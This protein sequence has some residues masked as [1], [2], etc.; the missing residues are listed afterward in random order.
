MIKVALLIFALLVPASAVSFPV[1]PLG[2]CFDGV[3]KLCSGNAYPGSEIAYS[4]IMDGGQGHVWL[5]Q[6]DMIIDPY[7]GERSNETVRWV[8]EG[9]FKTFE[10]FH[11]SLKVSF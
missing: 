1:A 10:E 5:R 4:S 2:M 9:T 11:A 7:W 8:P 6:G 3:E